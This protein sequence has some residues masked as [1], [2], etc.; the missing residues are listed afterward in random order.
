MAEWEEE[1]KGVAINS[2]ELELV[3]GGKASVG[4]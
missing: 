2:E 3:D 4:C 1:E